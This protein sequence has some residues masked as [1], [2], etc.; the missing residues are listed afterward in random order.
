MIVII[1][2]LTVFYEAFKYY[3]GAHNIHIRVKLL[4]NLYH[5]CPT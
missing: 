5:L 3:V 4:S 1:Y 2:I